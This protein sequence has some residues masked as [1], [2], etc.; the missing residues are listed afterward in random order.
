MKNKVTAGTVWQVNREQILRVGNKFTGAGSKKVVPMGFVP[1]GTNSLGKKFPRNK[2]TGE[3]IPPHKRSAHVD[4]VHAMNDSW[5]VICLHDIDS[6]EL[7]RLPD[8]QC[9]STLYSSAVRGSRSTRA[10]QCSVVRPMHPRQ[11]TRST[12]LRFSN[13]FVI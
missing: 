8:R 7:K 4:D 12:R 5:I 3:Q 10:T 13:V 6:K 2:F 11:F 1:H 9:A